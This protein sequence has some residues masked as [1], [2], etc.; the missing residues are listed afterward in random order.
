MFKSVL[1][2]I[3]HIV[4]WFLISNPPGTGNINADSV[5]TDQISIKGN[6]FVV[7]HKPRPTFLKPRVGARAG[8]QQSCFDPFAAAPDIF[9]MQ[10]SPDVILA[11]MALRYQC[12]RPQF[13]F[14]H[15]IF[16][17][18]AGTAHRLDFIWTFD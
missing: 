16:T 13:H 4:S 15:G 14:R 11:H 8:C 1:H 17:S 18:K 9:S 12:P 2:G 3:H 10:D 6:N 5:T 7:L